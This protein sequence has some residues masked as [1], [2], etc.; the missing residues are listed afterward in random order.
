M[1]LQNAPKYSINSDVNVL[2]CLA[3]QKCSVS[4]FYAAVN[5]NAIKFKYT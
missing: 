4:T 5:D 1:L 3:F 2:S